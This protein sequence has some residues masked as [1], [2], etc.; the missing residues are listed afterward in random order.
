MDP[1]KSARKFFD[2]LKTVEG[3]EEMALTV[4]AQGVQGSEWPDRYAKHEEL[5]KGVCG[6]IQHEW[7][8]WEE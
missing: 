1:E 6:A 2:A 4:A 5:A 3:W 7:R 8:G